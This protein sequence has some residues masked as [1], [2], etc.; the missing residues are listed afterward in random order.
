M[1]II[2]STKHSKTIEELHNKA[3][4]R[5]AMTALSKYTEMKNHAHVHY[6]APVRAVFAG[7]GRLAPCIVY[8]NSNGGQF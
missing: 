4:N 7:G 6:A 1:K 3:Q 5:M 2:E 8:K